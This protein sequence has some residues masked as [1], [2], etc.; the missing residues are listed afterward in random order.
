MCLVISSTTLSSGS[1]MVY[2]HDD[3]CTTLGVSLCP[4]VCGERK[5]ACSATDSVS[6]T[7]KM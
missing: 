1:A 3:K 2:A 6:Q 7:G 5:A 4:C